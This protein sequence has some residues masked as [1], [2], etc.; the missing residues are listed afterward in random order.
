MTKQDKKLLNEAQTRRWMKLAKIDNLSEQ[1]IKERYEEEGVK[2]E[3]E[4]VQ[5]ST[6]G[7]KLSQ[8]PVKQGGN[9][10]M[11]QETLHK[12]E[13]TVHKE[14]ENLQ[15][16]MPEESPEEAPVGGPPDAGHQEPDGDEVVSEPM[17]AELVKAIADAITAQTG[18]AV[19][20]EGA[21]GGEEGG[22]E[23]PPMPGPEGGEEPAGGGMPPMEETGS[24][25]TE[26][27][28]PPDRKPDI[29]REGKQRVVKEEFSQAPKVTKQNQSNQGTVKDPYKS[30]VK[31][32]GVE[33]PV[34]AGTN[35]YPHKMKALEEELRKRVYARIMEDL[36]RVKEGTV[37]ENKKPAAPAT[38]AKKK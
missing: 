27:A 22:E 33:K 16:V 31:V 6:E 23:M 2:K 24:K 26:E 7:A 11:A 36:K 15:E 32:Q 21:P 37:K 5:R 38:P 25:R 19:D 30:Q 8:T 35:S 28:T 13:E 4:T 29:A 9:K 12:E 1:F 3:E 18:V 34:S 10:T 20:V 17:V 14:E